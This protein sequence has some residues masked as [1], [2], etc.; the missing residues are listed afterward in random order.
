MCLLAQLPKTDNTAVSFF[1][2]VMLV[3]AYDDR[4]FHETPTDLYLLLQCF[5]VFFFPNVAFNFVFGNFL[6]HVLEAHVHRVE[7]EIRDV[8]FLKS[9]SCSPSSYSNLNYRSVLNFLNSVH[10]DQWDRT[11]I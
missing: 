3:V 5:C 9:A 4:R 7:L 11:V 6:H 10:T 2:Q 1:H 8:E